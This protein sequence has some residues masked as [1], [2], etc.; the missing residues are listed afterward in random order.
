[1]RIHT[2][3][4]GLCDIGATRCL[5]GEADNHKAGRN[6]WHSKSPHC[7]IPDTDLLIRLCLHQLCDVCR[8]NAV[9]NLVGDLE[10][11]VLDNDTKSTLERDWSSRAL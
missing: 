5:D 1:M 10:V 2:T 6:E 7:C 11:G 3:A 9:A 4:G 8:P